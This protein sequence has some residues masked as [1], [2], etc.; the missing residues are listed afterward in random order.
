[1]PRR[2]IRA[3]YEQLSEFERGRIIE[4]KEA[5]WENWRITLRMGRSGVAIRRCS[6]E[7]VENG[8]FQRHDA[9]VF[10]HE[11]HFQ[12]CPDDHRGRVWRSPEQR[13]D[14]AFTIASHTGPQS[15]V[16]VWGAISFDSRTPFQH[17]GL[18]LQQDNARPHV[19]R[20]AMNCLTACQ[21]LPW[22]DRSPDLSP[23][24]HVYDMMGRRLH[25]RG[26][27]HDLDR[28]LEKICQE[29]PQE[30]TRVF[31]HSMARCVTAY[32]QS[33]DRLLFYAKY[34][35][36][37]LENK[38]VFCDHFGVRYTSIYMIRKFH[39]KPMSG[40]LDK[41][42]SR[43]LGPISQRILVRHPNCGTQNNWDNAGKVIF[44]QKINYPAS[45]VSDGN[46]GC[47]FICGNIKKLF[48]EVRIYHQRGRDESVVDSEGSSS[49]GP[50]VW[51]HP[52]RREGR[53]KET[54]RENE[55]LPGHGRKISTLREDNLEVTGSTRGER[56]PSSI[57]S[58]PSNGKNDKER[59]LSRPV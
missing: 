21:T 9:K 16:I 57:S 34:S 13:A 27:V 32:I 15:G 23:S 53:R 56:V 44:R 22:S 47:G 54:M 38:N 37:L 58:G 49:G 7:W 20:V 39:N 50:R 41:R 12:L 42:Q 45:E 26:N 43:E 40:H 8:K 51:M 48:E 31:Y 2:G 35:A 30:T 29:I 46:H 55:A 10:S 11:A 25:L 18:I 17:P 14:P 59:D 3:Y 5:G 1:M 24:Q 36:T 28:Q 19:V 4:L 33:V 6:Q 52:G